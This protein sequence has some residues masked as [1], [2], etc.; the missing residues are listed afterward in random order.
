MNLDVVNGKAIGEGQYE[1]GFDHYLS[2]RVAGCRK[3]CARVYQNEGRRTIPKATRIQ[4]AAPAQAYARIGRTA[5][6]QKI[7]REF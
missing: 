3:S 6:A 7:A 4:H 5:D 2:A 1:T